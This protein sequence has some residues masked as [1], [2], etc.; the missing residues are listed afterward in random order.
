M[1]P[2]QT[3]LSCPHGRSLVVH[4]P[5]L[6]TPASDPSVPRTRRPIHLDHR[7][8]SAVSVARPSPERGVVEPTPLLGS[9]GY[10]CRFRPQNSGRSMETLEVPRLPGAMT[11]TTWVP[12][13]LRPLHF[14]LPLPVADCKIWPLRGSISGSRSSPSRPVSYS[15]LSC[16]PLSLWPSPSLCLCPSASSLASLGSLPQRSSSPSLLKEP[17]GRA[18]E[19][20]LVRP[21]SVHQAPS[22]TAPPHA[23]DPDLNRNGNVPRPAGK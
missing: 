17:E 9:V 13:S 18:R 3:L 20:P 5:S 21:S 6:H 4:V 1:N 16:L 23:L 2:T 10:E 12:G 14:D 7:T 19:G 11:G 22:V 15:S 8:P